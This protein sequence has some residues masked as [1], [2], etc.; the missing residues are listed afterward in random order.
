MPWQEMKPMDQKLL[1]IADHLRGHFS[2]SELC[3]RYGISRK[4]GYKW[5]E[6]YRQA[7][8]EG[9]KEQSRRPHRSPLTTPYSLRK[10]IIELRNKYRVPLGAKK[11]RAIL[12][13]RF[14]NQVVPSKSTIY[15]ILNAEGLVKHRKRRTRV[16]PYPQP[17]DPVTA[18]NELWSTDYKGQFKLGNGQWCY[19]LTVMDHHSR[20]LLGCQG[21]KGTKT[22][23]ARSC[24]IKLF[25]EY[26]LPQR[27]RSDNGVPFASRATAG[28]SK[29]SIWWI[30]LG[31]VPER[32]EPGKPQQNGRHERMHRTMKRATTRP[33][34]ASFAAQQRQ[35]EAFRREYNEQRPHEGL[36]QT[37]PSSHYVRSVREY[38]SRLPQPIYPDYFDIKQVHSCGVIAAHG[39]QVYVSHLLTGEQVG[40]EEID[41]G[42][43]EIYFGPIRLGSYDLRD[44]QGWDTPYWTVKV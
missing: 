26:G 10:A 23:I 32:I 33:A 20:Y 38:P 4:T 34:S 6:R 35:F 31:I 29:L 27:I 7:N 30:R 1:F 14:P 18:P 41:D 12:E 5:L 3:R 19:P 42:K 16:S 8:L 37:T 2:H 43:W 11:I 17:F 44:K 28:L 22:Q 9:L 40:I 24:F 15:N 39:G 25:K 21:V 36:G 13:Q